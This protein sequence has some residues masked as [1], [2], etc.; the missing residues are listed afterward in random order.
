[1]QARLTHLSLSSPRIASFERL[2][3]LADLHQQ[4]RAGDAARYLAK[5]PTAILIPGDWI[6]VSDKREKGRKETLALLGEL[7]S[8][9]PV[10]YSLGNHEA[11]A[12]GNRPPDENAAAA[13]SP[14]TV[15]LCETLTS[16][17][18][19]VLC[20]RYVRHG[21]LCIG[22]LTSAG[23]RRLDTSWLDGL[24]REDGYRL[25][26]CHH[27]EYYDRYVRPYALDLTV[28]GHAHGGQW[29]LF[30]R[31]LY[32]PGQGILP[33]Y[34]DGFYDGGRLLVSRGLSERWPVPRLFNPKE[35]ILLELHPE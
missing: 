6:E 34:T 4:A 9:C 31:G 27:P 26:L 1:M 10:Y 13:L 19:T 32:A 28:G 12:R 22:G 29:K 5:E 25:L 15:A 17:G 24:A 14:R 11:G 20:D 7:A 30:G 18:V 21:S 2:L 23:G 35:A 8:A 16:L 33:R 3:V